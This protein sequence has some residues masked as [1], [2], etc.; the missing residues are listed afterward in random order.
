MILT[1]R[2][3]GGFAGIRETL[4]TV[5]TASL[6][7][8]A[9]RAL[10]AQL[11][12]LELEAEPA[13]GADQFHYEVEIQEPGAASRT[14]VIVDEGDPSLPGYRVLRDLAQ[15]LGLPVL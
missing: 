8:A 5:D 7:G 3:T 6:G 10:A 2:R 1:L 11:K 4:G 13:F 15:T 9:Q 12:A 14:L